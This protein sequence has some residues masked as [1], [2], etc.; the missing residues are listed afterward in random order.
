MKLPATVGA[1]WT[2]SLN[3]VIGRNGKIPS[4]FVDNYEYIYDLTR[5]STLVMGRK[6]FENLPPWIPIR[7]NT[8]VLSRKEKYFLPPYITLVTDLNK[9]EINT[10]SVFF[11]GGKE[12]FDL[13]LPYVNRLD[14]TTQNIF[15][16]GE[17][18]G[19]DVRELLKDPKWQ[20]K[21][22]ESFIGPK[23][24]FLARCKYVKD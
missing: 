2:N 14:I 22:T 20:L 3:N 9:L 15:V 13:I 10:S 8:V 1:V 23:G 18:K 11:L 6:T 19:P 21:S 12:I 16:E 17:L 7:R 4:E 5:Q 24:F